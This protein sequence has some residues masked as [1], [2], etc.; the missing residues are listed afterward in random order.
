MKLEKF[1]E[2]TRGHIYYLIPVAL[3][4]LTSLLHFFLR[5]NTFYALV[6]T[7]AVFAVWVS[8]VAFNKRFVVSPVLYFALTMIVVNSGFTVYE[9]RKLHTLIPDAIAENDTHGAYA[10]LDS[11]DSD[12]IIG[13]EQYSN[14][15]KY[16]G[17][18]V[19]EEIRTLIRNA[20]VSLQ[21]NDTVTARENV[22]K[23]LEYDTDN[24]TAL[25]LMKRIEKLEYAE[26]LKKL[27][28]AMKISL[29]K[30]R[31]KISYYLNRKNFTE[32]GNQI[33]MFLSENKEL[34]KDNPVIVQ[35][36]KSIETS[37][38]K[39]S[40]AR[41]VIE[42]RRMYGKAYYLYKK[43]KYSDSIDL[44]E[45]IL[46]KNKDHRSAKWL[47]KKATVKRSRARKEFWSD[48]FGGAIVVILILLYIRRKTRY[49]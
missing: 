19:K 4:I 6:I 8:I 31:T 49:Y 37:E 12:V 11:I 29:S 7:Q 40:T 25:E 34:K 1:F 21:K 32:A 33:K 28:P 46:E 23:I 26:S 2:D 35:L 10:I 5:T 47:L 48:F 44:L 39:L 18:R 20:G 42:T 15:K 30:L 16:I 43:K 13:S 22:S 17:N 14:T 27:T 36:F 3:L 24:N 41:Q 9:F 38:Q 45:N